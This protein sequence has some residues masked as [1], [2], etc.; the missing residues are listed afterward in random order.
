MRSTP[1]RLIAIMIVAAFFIS[2][3]AALSAKERRGAQLIVTRLD[4][5]QVSGELM[6][7]KPD[8]LFLLSGGKDLSVPLAD[9]RTVRIVRRSRAGLGGALV[10]AAI[11]GGVWEINEW[12]G[13]EEAGALMLIPLGALVG[14]AIRSVAGLD[15]SFAV[16]GQ[17]EA[18]VGRHMNLLREYSREER[19]TEN[20]GKSPGPRHRPRFR[21]SLSV[22]ENR[23]RGGD[24]SGN[25][26]FF[27]PE[28]APPD[29][30]PYPLSLYQWFSNGWAFSGP[31]GLAYELT[32][33]WSA[34]VEYFVFR[35]VSSSAAGMMRYTSSADGKT[36]GGPFHQEYEARATCLLA[37]LTYRPLALSVFR[38][39]SIEF[40]AA[41]G[42]AL[43][44]GVP[45]EFSFLAFPVFQK[46]A[47]SGRVHASYDYYFV[48]RLSAGGLS[49]GTFIG[50]RFMETSFS[51]IAGSGHGSFQEEGISDPPS[52][53]RLA[54][55]TLPSFPI[56]GSGVFWGFRV[57]FRI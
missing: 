27:L 9:V 38:R 23:F 48:P 20:T 30:G 14:M 17:P 10:G 18:V 31:A 8:S 4:G 29:T 50:Y 3:P 35:H 32:E 43:V 34:E 37:G 5:S 25:G 12:L 51:G 55:V 49:V 57:G 28:E 44:K 52:F 46:V 24:L 56:K 47:F 22:S 41:V 19:L 54:E 13:E 11:G 53:E 40:G 36:Y 26:S 6:A 7:V 39:Y 21:L 1:V 45:R 42:P 33:H 2:A 15:S 16:A